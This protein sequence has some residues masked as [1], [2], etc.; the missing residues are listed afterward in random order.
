DGDPV[1]RP[2]DRHD[3]RAG[4]ARQ[5]GRRQQRSQTLQGQDRRAQARDQ[6][7][8]L[9]HEDPLLSAKRQQPVKPVHAL[10]GAAVAAATVA[11]WR[12][13]P[14]A[15]PHSPTAPAVTLDAP[16]STT[17]CFECIRGT[18][19]LNSTVDPASGRTIA[20][21]QFQYAPAGTSNWTTI[22]NDT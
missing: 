19:T 13:E 10:L 11:F 16:V 20:G 17:G 7:Q 8:A 18:I 14:G 22:F 1:P 3:R 6:P 5:E 4:P 9:A 21:V 2:A 15:A 12:A